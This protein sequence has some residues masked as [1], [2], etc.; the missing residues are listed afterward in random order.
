M[1]DYSVNILDNENT[2][3]VAKEA[4]YSGVEA[5]T[6]YLVNTDEGFELSVVVRPDVPMGFMEGIGFVATMAC[7]HGFEKQSFR[8][9]KVFWP[10]TIMKDLMNFARVECRA[11]YAD[12]MFAVVTVY[13]NQEYN[14]YI[15]RA[16]IKEILKDVASWEE[17]IKAKKINAGP[18]AG[19]IS[20]YFD[21]THLLGENVAIASDAGRIVCAGTFGG[22]DVWGRACIVLEDGSEVDFSH[23]QGN[24]IE[25]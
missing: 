20:E 6:C 14:E 23:R 1:S 2:S 11:G 17:D 24:V 16:L 8:D 12:G 13:C 7:V 22:L 5:G 21:Y 15:G 10:F 19:V 18:A 25:L 4:A 9:L 3:E